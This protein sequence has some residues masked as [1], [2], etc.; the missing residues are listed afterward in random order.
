MFPNILLF[1]DAYRT[2]L[3]GREAD[4]FV[5]IAASNFMAGAAAG[6]TT[7]VIIYP[8]D[9]AHTRLAADV[10]RTDSRQFRGISHFLQTIYKKDGI[11]G[12]YRGLPASIHGMIVQGFPRLVSYPLDTTRRRLMMQSGLEKPMYH[13][14]LDC[15]RKIYR[16]GGLTSFYRGAIS[17][18][19]RSSY[20]GVV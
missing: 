18:M 17:N 14:T 11:R 6:C 7:L 1:Q 9:V 20:T 15:W 2:I 4:R 10:G 3:K 8:L 12:I 5:S 16:F 13:S 19:F